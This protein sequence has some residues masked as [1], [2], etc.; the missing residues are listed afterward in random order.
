[1]FTNITVNCLDLNKFSQN[2]LGEYVVWEWG[3]LFPLVEFLK[4]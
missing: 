3:F 1:M 2:K 4:A